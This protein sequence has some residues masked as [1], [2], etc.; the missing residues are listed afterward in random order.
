MIDEYIPREAALKAIYTSTTPALEIEAIPAAEGGSMSRYMKRED[1]VFAACKVL[2]KF[3]G[4]TMGP[5]CPDVG[6]REVRDII[7]AFQMIE[8]PEKH[9][10]LIDADALRQS[11]KESIDECNKW[12]DEVE[13]DEMYARV[14]QS[15]GTFVE[16]SLRVKVAPTIIPA[17]DKEAE[18]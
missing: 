3:G 4:C 10:R 2:D 7:D 5:A 12:A 18:A 13:S 11:I 6:C 14:S 1:A 17:S 8:I 15:L 9:G 16:C